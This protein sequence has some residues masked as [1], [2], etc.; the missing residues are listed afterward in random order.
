[1]MRKDTAG[2]D[3]LEHHV[4]KFVAEYGLPNFNRLRNTQ[5]NDTDANSLQRSFVLLD[6]Y[7]LQCNGATSIIPTVFDDISALKIEKDVYYQ[8]KSRNF[9]SIDSFFIFD[10]DVFA[11][12][13]TVGTKKN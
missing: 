6:D 4:H 9:A 7:E 3:L 12:Q 11:F 5:Y 8:S 13:I 1:M 2:G 10:N